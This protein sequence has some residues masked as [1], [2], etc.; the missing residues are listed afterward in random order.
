MLPTAVKFAAGAVDAVRRPAAGLVVLIYHRVG[1]HTGVRVDLPTPTFDAQMAALAE[2]GNVLALDDAVER[3][4]RGEDLQ[5]HVVVTF[6]DGTDDFVDEALPVLARHE[7]PATLYVATAHVEERIDFP[8]NGRPASWAG[9]GECVASGLVTIGSH[10]HRHVLLDRL[11][12][13]EVA[14]E[15][16]RSVDLIGERLGIAAAHFAYPKALRPSP[17]AER[18]VRA[19]FSSAAL[20]GTRRQPGRD[21]RPSTRPYPR[22]DHR[23][24]ALVRPQGRR[25]HGVRGRSAA[26]R[27]P[28]SLCGGDR[29]TARRLVHLTTTAMSLDWLLRPQLEA[30]ADAGFDVIG[31]SAP[32]PHVDALR[33]SG[34]QHVAIPSLTRSMSP[35][36]DLRGPTRRVSRRCAV[37]DPTSCTPTIR[38]Q[39]CWAGWPPAPPVCR[40][41]STP[42]TVS[43][44]C[45]TID[46]PSG[47]SSTVSSA[48]PAAARMPSS[49]RTPRTS[50]CFVASGVPH[51]KLSVL[52][53]GVDLTRFDPASVDATARTRI[54]ASLGIGDATVVVG[55]VGRLV[56]EKGYATV[57]EAAEAMS[58]RDCR[59]VVVG[60]EE[61]DKP[62]AVT[63]ADRAEAE[64]HGV[65]FLG[66]RD[67]MVDIYS[68]FDVHVLASHREGYPRSAMEASAMGL[69]VVATNIRGCRQVVA[70]GVS[71]T[72]FEV[73]DA[74]GLVDALTPLVADEVRRTRMGEAARRRAVEHF[75]DRDVINTTLRI[76]EWLLSGVGAPALALS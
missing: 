57:F 30:F 3:L 1:G 39:A 33:A 7:V 18:E 53:N 34:I 50:R 70:D 31:M 22:P 29:M 42:C 65:V 35:I 48:W 37:S 67:D 41:S 21:R 62:G 20:A 60:P 68:A 9:L 24:R 43:T 58:D 28:A 73:D 72:L 12:D 14:G 8:D 25:R 47:P 64:R 59:F 15:L 5:N 69:P 63:A 66:R 40:S 71:G 46:W 75:D 26:P 10:T 4:R 38:S 45:P 2:A 51:A 74:R 55:L 16:A 61:P 17:A 76:Y 19:R 54:R 52:G 13:T 44:R 6:D 23:R 27:E 11:P 32:G 56:W 49:S 36:Q